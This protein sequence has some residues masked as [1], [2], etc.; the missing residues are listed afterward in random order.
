MSDMRFTEDHE[1]VRVDGKSATIGITGYAQEQLG[2]I[3]FVDLPESGARFAQGEDAA[4]VE[5]VKAASDI[6]APVSGE[7]EAVNDALD[8]E[9]GLAN[10]DPEGDGWFFKVILG[11]PGELD[12]LMDAD[13]YKAF[14][15]KL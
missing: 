3:V 15:A 4:V 1:W 10:K 11:D 14:V 2:D 5:S 12:D 6:H 13:A 9:P 8:A 7:V